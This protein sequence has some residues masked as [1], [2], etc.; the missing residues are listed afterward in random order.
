MRYVC[1][2]PCGNT[3]IS[4][5]NRSLA[6][7]GGRIFKLLLLCVCVT[8]CWPQ[9]SGVISS[10][11]DGLQLLCLTGVEDQLQSDVRPTLELLRDAGIR[12]SGTHT[13]CIRSM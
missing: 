10:L 2:A 11:E 3:T 12:V 1:T 6:G 9:V 8:L 4:A 7:G 5:L 13:I